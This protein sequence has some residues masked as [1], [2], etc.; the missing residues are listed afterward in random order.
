MTSGRS[1][2]KVVIEGDNAVYFGT[3]KIERIGDE[4]HGHVG[5]K[6]KGGLDRMQNRQERSFAF[7]ML[8]DYGADG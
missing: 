8:R 3:A 6:P 7:E 2:A 5:D 1:A 4:W